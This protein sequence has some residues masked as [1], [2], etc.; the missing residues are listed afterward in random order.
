[1]LRCERMDVQIFDEE[2][3]QIT[4]RDP[5][6][7]FTPL[8]K[9]TA[10]RRSSHP[11][12]VVETIKGR[13]VR[14]DLRTEIDDESGTE[15]FFSATEERSE[16]VD[17]VK[18]PR[19]AEENAARL[20]RVQKGTLLANQQAVDID[21][22]D[23]A[24][25]D[26]RDSAVQEE[27]G[28]KSIALDEVILSTTTKSQFPEPLLSSPLIRPPVK[29]P[30]MV[31]A[32]LPQRLAP[33]KAYS[34]TSLRYPPGYKEDPAIATEVCRCS[35]EKYTPR[36]Q[37][38]PNMTKYH[39]VAGYTRS[40]FAGFMPNQPLV[41]LDGSASRHSPQMT[42]GSKYHPI[43]SILAPVAPPL[44]PNRLSI[45]S[46]FSTYGSQQQLDTSNNSSRL[47]PV[48]PDFMPAQQQAELIGTESTNSKTMVHQSHLANGHSTRRRRRRK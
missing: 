35:E 19:T 37:Y 24:Q 23:Q 7:T 39:T 28:Q 27:A 17:R 25:R 20:K 4:Y 2:T 14:K 34:Y 9:H 21:R 38:T 45:A 26:R 30:G 36:G 46:Q 43:S 47:R 5:T 48:A 32:T 16:R 40:E 8:F 10:R 42:E 6:Q 1:M 11:T 31:K 12:T 3:L 18:A 15:K 44:A 29:L 22:R 33:P 13:D 41:S